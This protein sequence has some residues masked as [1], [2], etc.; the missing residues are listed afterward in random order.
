L[1][2]GISKYGKTTDV[3]KKVYPCPIT[4]LAPKMIDGTKEYPETIEE[5]T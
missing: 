5:E 3:I 4:T 2:F 1:P